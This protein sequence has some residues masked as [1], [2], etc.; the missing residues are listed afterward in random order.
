MRGL[1]VKLFH[2]C[3]AVLECGFGVVGNACALIF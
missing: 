3:H 2:L 1:P